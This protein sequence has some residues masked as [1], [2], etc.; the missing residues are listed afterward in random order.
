MPVYRP[1]K[2]SD[3]HWCSAND[4]GAVSCTVAVVLGAAEDAE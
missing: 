4:S 2:A 1:A 3:V